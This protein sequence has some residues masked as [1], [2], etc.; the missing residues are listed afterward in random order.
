MYKAVI[1]RCRY[2]YYLILIYRQ[3]GGQR[4]ARLEPA[5]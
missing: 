2:L 1:I 5:G 3:T 4:D